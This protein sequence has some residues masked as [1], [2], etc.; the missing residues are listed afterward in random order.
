MGCNY[1]PPTSALGWVP[2]VLLVDNICRAPPYPLTLGPGF[3][4][5]GGPVFPSLVGT[6]AWVDTKPP[7]PCLLPITPLYFFPPLEP[8]AVCWPVARAETCATP[9]VPPLCSL[10]LPSIVLSSYL[11]AAM[12][13]LRYMLPL[14]ILVANSCPP[15]FWGI[16]VNYWVIT[17]FSPW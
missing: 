4:W 10:S 5:L 16:D 17:L 3:P 11:P 2:I 15:L 7:L 12:A 1:W 6:T 9:Y 13:P 14:P 8:F